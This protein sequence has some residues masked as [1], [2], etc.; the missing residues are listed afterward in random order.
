MTAGCFAVLAD[1]GLQDLLFWGV[2]IIAGLGGALVGWFIMPP[3]IRILLR[4][5]FHKP[6][7]NWV[8]S[9]LRL[10]GAVLFGIFVAFCVHLGGGFGFGPGGG[11]GGYGSGSGKNGKGGDGT[12][13][14]AD[15]K[16]V[17]DSSAKSAELENKARDSLPIELL[18]GQRYKGDERYYLIERKEPA[19]TLA[20][21]DEFLQKNPGK[22]KMVQIVLTPES[23]FEE[24]RAVTSLRERVVQKYK[25]VPYIEQVP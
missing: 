21:V 22:Y 2:R 6:A 23:V 18:G 3:L 8:V 13:K 17:T 24:H 5:A 19:R 9:W 11:G 7:P 25:L 16:K 1:L 12:S 15:A 10:V 20:E 4:L 14:V